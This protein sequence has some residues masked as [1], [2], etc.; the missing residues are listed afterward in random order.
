MDHVI[1]NNT[2]IERERERERERDRDDM[3]PVI[4][5]PICQQQISDSSVV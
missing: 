4:V 2:P 5:W 1:R 3:R